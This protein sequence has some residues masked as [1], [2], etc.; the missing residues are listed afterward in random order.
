MPQPRSSE[1]EEAKV[2]IH[3]NPEKFKEEDFSMRKM[4]KEEEQIVPQPLPVGEFWLH[5]AGLLSWCSQ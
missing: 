5:P 4:F 2:G 3:I 1:S